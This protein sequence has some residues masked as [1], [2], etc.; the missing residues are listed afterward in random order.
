L[1]AGV[2]HGR[3]VLRDAAGVD[4]LLHADLGVLVRV[5]EQGQIQLQGVVEQCRFEAEFVVVRGF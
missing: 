3:H 1:L 2:Q 4:E 5:V